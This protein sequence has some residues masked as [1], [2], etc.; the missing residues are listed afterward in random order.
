MSTKVVINGLGRIG[1]SILKLVIE[2]PA[3]ELV[4]VND[5]VEAENLAYLLRFDTAYGRYAKTVTVE[6]GGLAIAGRKLRTLTERDPPSLPWKE[7]GIELVFECT[8]A[9]TKRKDL[10]KHIRA[11]AQWVLLSAPTGSV[12]TV[13]HGTNVPRGKPN[14]ISRA[15]CP[16]ID[17]ASFAQQVE[18]AKANCP[19][20]KALAGTQITLAATLISK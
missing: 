6:G 5:L 20:S 4:A 12:Q 19:V 9:H 16:G 8:G 7:L 15:N 14:I 10:E 17:A 2:E 3:L 13:I 1:R 18:K 11:G